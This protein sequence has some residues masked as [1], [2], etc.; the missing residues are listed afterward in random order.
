[1]RDI[2]FVGI[3]PS[4]SSTGLVIL[5]ESAKVIHQASIKA[6]KEDD[7]LRFMTLT[8]KVRKQ[9]NTETD[10]VIIEG[11]SFGS[12]GAGVSKMYGIGWTLRIM[13]EKEGFSWTEA[14]PSAVKKFGSN[15]GNAKKEDLVLP[16]YKKWGFESTVND[17]TDAYI[18]A[19]IAYSMY[20][21]DDLLT[22]EKEVLKK[23]K[24]I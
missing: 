12:K 20:N 7:P 19:R 13:L 9:L 18:M 3:D 23:V 6:G 16:V 15:K 5:D 11:F 2:R 1:M 4:L 8:A 21:Q 22:Y 17:I 14:T 10:K 24:K